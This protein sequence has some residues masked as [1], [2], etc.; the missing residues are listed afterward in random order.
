MA[1][2]KKLDL[3]IASQ[4]Q[5]DG[6]IGKALDVAALILNDDPDSAAALFI[7]AW[8]FIKSEKYGLAYTLLKRSAEINPRQET[9]NNMG[10]ALIGMQ[11]FEAAEKALRKAL[12]KNPEHTQ[13]TN[14]LALISVYNC[15][16]HEAIKHAEKSLAIDPGQFD[17]RETLGYAHLMLGEYRKGWMGYESMVGNSKYR[18]N[19]PPHD[20]CVYWLGEKDIKLYLRGEQGLGDEISFSSIFPDL[21]KDCPDVTFECDGKLEGLFKRSF[22]TI[23]IHG[24]RHTKES[25]WRDG[26]TYD[27]HALVGT[28]AKYYRNEES[29][30]PGTPFLVADPERRVQWRALLD[31]LPGKKVGIAW[32]GGMRNTFSGRRSFSLEG[33]LPIL[34]TPGITWV[35]LQYK[36]PTDEIAALEESHG[37]KIHHWKR[38]AESADYDDQ[39]ALVAE[40]DCVV[41]VQT[42]VIHLAGALGVKTYCLVP[43]KPRWF[44]RMSGSKLPWYNSVEIFR[45]TDKWPVEKLALRLKD[46]LCITP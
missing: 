44:Y 45:Q 17:V 16:P 31:T 41:S 30:F 13:A 10:M 37:I 3:A 32:T 18:P 39:A 35:S 7:A 6:E 43:S 9:W 14:N 19:K 28:L 25:E 20:G 34:K 36:D 42:A 22:P 1:S 26:E 15:N 29:A 11:M 27:A 38:A 2:N 21:L 46:D 24:T 12:K 40:L 5:K 23:K 33:L 4:Y 8:S